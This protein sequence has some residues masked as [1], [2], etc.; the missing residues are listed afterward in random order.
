MISGMSILDFQILTVIFRFLKK[1][2]K[3]DANYVHLFLNFFRKRF[4]VC[5]NWFIFFFPKLIFALLF[6]FPV[7]K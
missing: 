5:E 4:L 7:G 2:D 3:N 6:H 1:N